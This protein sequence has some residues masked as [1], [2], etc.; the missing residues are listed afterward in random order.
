M[1]GHVLTIEALTVLS[2]FKGGA[3]LHGHAIH[4]Q[5]GYNPGTVNNMLHRLADYGILSSTVEAVDHRLSSRVP[6]IFYKLTDDGRQT[7]REIRDLCST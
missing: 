7:M 5:T 4:Q 2:L 3:K 1:S 6:R